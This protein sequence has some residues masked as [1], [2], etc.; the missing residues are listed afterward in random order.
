[1][2]ESFMAED[3]VSKSKKGYDRLA[4]Y[5]ETLER[6]AFGNRLMHARTALLDDLPPL[7]KVLI[8]GEGD[9]RFLSAFLQ[10]QPECSVTCLEQ[11]SSMIELARARLTK[12]QQRKVTFVTKDALLF[13]PQ[14]AH[15]DGLV[16]A[17]FLDC[18]TPKTLQN[19]VPKL[20]AALQAGGWWY[21]ADFAVP[22]QGW[23]RLRA[24]VYLTTMHAFFRWQTGLQARS[25][26]DPTPLFERRLEPVKR[27]ETSH[28]LLT[29]QLYRRLE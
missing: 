8:L 7:E 12:R 22:S 26:A 9:G 24:Q 19:L 20:A 4:P 10:R 5:Y 27:L 17:F 16:T 14:R 6:L 23:R 29:T 1:M 28:G 11:S 21:Y 13:A 25:L 3:S 2:A 15:Y 18:F